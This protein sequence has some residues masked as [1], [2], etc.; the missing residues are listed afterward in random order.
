[1]VAIDESKQIANG[2]AMTDFITTC[3]KRFKERHELSWTQLSEL[4]GIPVVNFYRLKAKG[5]FN[6]H[7]KFWPQIVR[8][9]GPQF[10]RGAD[11]PGPM[12]P[13]SIEGNPLLIPLLG[14]HYADVRDPISSANVVSPVDTAEVSRLQQEIETIRG[15][16]KE[17]EALI[18]DHSQLAK[19][20]DS[21]KRELRKA[22]DEIL[23]LGEVAASLE[24]SKNK[25]KMTVTQLQATI[26]TL[27]ND[28]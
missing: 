19:E 4:T 13:T 20:R 2:S 23:R 21:L 9:F 27:Q 26:E 15:R 25:L 14:L 22:N 10:L 28:L 6:K 3:I 24:K 7:P 17:R 11:H 18:A 12:N 5:R 8:Y 16:L 1:M